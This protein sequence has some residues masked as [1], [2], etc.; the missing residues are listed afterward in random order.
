MVP[1]ITVYLII[2][3]NG[4]EKKKPTKPATLKSMFVEIRL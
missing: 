1:K 2:K 4:T 3:E